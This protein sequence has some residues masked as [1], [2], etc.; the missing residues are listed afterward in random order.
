MTKVTI[1]SGFNPATAY[2]MGLISKT[3][4][5]KKDTLPAEFRAMGLEESVFIRGEETDTECAVLSDGSN[6]V[7]AFRGT[8][9]GDKES[10]VDDITTDLK[11]KR[12][13]GPFESEVHCGFKTA[14]DEVWE[15]VKDAVPGE[16]PLFITGH[17]LGAALANLCSAYFVEA[18]RKVS[19]LY[20]FGCPRVGDQTFADEMNRTLYRQ[21][22]RYVNNNDTVTRVP[23]RSFGYSHS[24]DLKYFT[25][26][27]EFEEDPSRWSRFLDRIKGRLEDFGEWGTDGLKDHGIDHYV[28]NLERAMR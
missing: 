17:S 12:V 3:I 1:T 23:P 16:K 21:H 11:I 24:G 26:S 5:K 7:V 8:E 2:A 13:P 28:E 6:I 10:A 4:Y 19:G 20:T 15:R 25:E 27:G 22:Y 9:T 14:M 18:G